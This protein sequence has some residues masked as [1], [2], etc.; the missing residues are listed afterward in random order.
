MQNR[1]LNN[2]SGRTDGSAVPIGMRQKSKMD[3]Y[4]LSVLRMAHKHLL[5]RR[6]QSLTLLLCL[7]FEEEGVFELFEGGCIA[8]D[9]RPSPARPSAPRSGPTL[10]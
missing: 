10:S 2:R 5:Q 9:V 4:F 3:E 7:N 6:V 1:A 8:A